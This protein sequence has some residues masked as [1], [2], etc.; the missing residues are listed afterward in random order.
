MKKTIF[1]K[2]I[3][4]LLA[5]SMI[6]T[7][8]G[9]GNRE[10]EIEKTK[11]SEADKDSIYAYEVMDWDEETLQNMG[12]IQFCNG[13]IYSSQYVYDEETG[14]STMYFVEY[15]M[16]G[17][18]LNR[19]V[20]PQG[21][22][23]ETG[24]SYGTNTM[25]VTKDENIFGIDYTYSN[26]YDD[27]TGEYIWKEEYSLVR[28]DKE[29]NKLWSNP[30]GGQGSD[31]VSD[32]MG[33]EEYY[34]VNNVEP[35]S[36]GNIWVFDTRACTAYDIEGNMIISFEGLKNPSG[37]FP[38]K[39]GNFVIG[40]WGENYD[41]LQYYKLDTVKA[42]IEKEPIVVP[43]TAYQYSYHAAIGT[44]YD[45]YATNSI[46]IWGFNWGDEE[47]V[48]V[49]DFILSD[50]EGTNIYNITPVSET[51]FIGTFYDMDWN[52]C[53]A[54]FTKVPAE[55]V[56]DKYIMN[57]ACH[58]L[59]TDIRRQ[60]I[61]FNRSHEDVRIVVEDYSAYVE[62]DNYNAG[63][64]KL[65]SDILAGKVPD[66]LVAS[67]DMDLSMYANKGLFADMYELMDSDETI[68]REDYL[69]NII[70]LGEYNGELYE[71]IP[72]F[73]AVTLVGKTSDVGDGFGWTYDE[74]NALM[75]QKGEDVHLL[76]EDTIRNTVMYYGINLAFNQFYNS[77][78]GECYF[79]SPEFVK[80]LELLKQFP[81]E[82][83]EDLWMQEDY[84]VTYETQW[85]EGR[86]ILRYN[87]IYDFRNYVENSQGYFGEEVSY[88]GFPTKEGMCG[89]SASVDFSLAIAEE[90]AFKQEAWEFVSY[91]IKDEYYEKGQYSGF[92]V[93]LSALD[94]K[95]EEEMK[96]NSWINEETGEEVSEDYYFWIGNEELILEMPTKEEC[97]YVIDFLKSITYRQRQ[98]NDITAII[99]EESASYFAGQKDAQSVAD[100][101]QGRV[102]IY[103]SEKR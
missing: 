42:E 97:Q 15:D 11:M 31:S 51:E 44:E 52:M 64:E 21:W 12:Q 10:K 54:S 80:Y 34:Y 62:E 53:L 91:F 63:I 94:K 20:I 5:F 25:V 86:S 102:K 18:E 45:V 2:S 3:V 36:N 100:I 89:S 61:D 23:E 17:N 40:S 92:P 14:E 16:D 77:N 101:I 85:R 7:F 79:D 35:D 72:Y 46:G 30:L 96:P 99:E 103:V 9:C 26:Y 90:S 59:S 28:F 29:G 74:V 56:A 6:L 47:M 95:A 76:S 13:K 38:T 49:M 87:Y 78:T 84:W 98:S 33:Y 32:D 60:V 37:V 83:N 57:M 4:L 71:L 67:Y 19:F 65:N 75:Q 88:I 1:K 55:E 22:D 82:I 48:K 27:N 73:N 41:T 66:I 8:V 70:A 68:K 50:F 43:G 93:K 58:Y 81:E 24:T 69:Q 39:D